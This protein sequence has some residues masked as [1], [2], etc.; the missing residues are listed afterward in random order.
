[1][2]SRNIA[3][4]DTLIMLELKAYNL[5]LFTKKHLEYY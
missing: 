4:V 5:M 3:K 1:M 2:A